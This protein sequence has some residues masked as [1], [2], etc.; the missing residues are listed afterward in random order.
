MSVL[1]ISYANVKDASKFKEYV[2]AVKPLLD[3][4]N[5]EVLVRGKYRETTNGDDAS[6]HIVAVFR[7]RDAESMARF[8]QSPEYLV[9][10]PLREMACDMTIVLYDEA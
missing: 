10:L 9:L 2:E 3:E 4:A 1:N 8:Y 7:Y 6:P 5:V